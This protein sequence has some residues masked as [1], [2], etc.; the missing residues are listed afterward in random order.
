MALVARRQGS[1][2]L[3]VV[4]VLLAL[5]L[6]A[7]LVWLLLP[8]ADVMAKHGRRLACVA[9]LREL[10]AGTAT[11]LSSNNDAFPLAWHVGGTSVADDLGN[12]LYS[13]FALYEACD[14]TGFSH[15]VT[16]RDVQEAV[17][18]LHAR[19]QKFH[20]T[21]LF[22]K[23]P[24]KG[25][26]DDYFAPELV[27]RRSGGPAR[28]GELVAAL[29]AAERPLFADV[30]A[31]FPDPNATHLQ[32]PGHDHEL[33]NGFSMVSE[34]GADVFLGVGP[35]LRVEGHLASSRLDFR[36]GNAANI[37]FLDGHADSLRPDDAPRLEALHR[38]WNHYL[39]GKP[40]GK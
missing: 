1:K 8:K 16:P 3:T 21:A 33:R 40:E 14:P 12:L 36:H 19:R 6:L 10:P 13:R 39:G 26:T 27:F 23:C 4:E 18:S 24:T 31:S 5:A 17:G 35:S 2:G 11:Y 38:A 9:K 20:L 29:P 25:W 15:V 34:S 32:D 37:V 28:K 22:W 7:V 30:N